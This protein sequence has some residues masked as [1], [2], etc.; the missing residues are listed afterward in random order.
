MAIIKTSWEKA[1]ADNEKDNYSSIMPTG[2]KQQ[3]YDTSI[4]PGGYL[5]HRCHVIAWKLGGIDV[6]ERNI[7]TGTQSFNIN[8]MKQFEDKV[9]NYLKEN[10]TNH[11]LYRVTP[12]FE[13]E[14]ELARGVNIEAYS[15]EDKG[16]IQFNVYVYNVQD[17]IIIDYATGKS[18][19]AEQEAKNLDLNLFDRKN[20]HSKDFIK[21]FIEELKNALKNMMNEGKNM[22]ENNS[23]NV[24]EEYNLY[25]RRKIFLDNKS[26]QG[27]DL[28]WIM[29]EKSVCIAEH[30][31]GGPCNISEIDL[32]ENAKV[33]DVYEKVEGTYVYNADI[34]D[35]LK[36]IK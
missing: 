33:G 2:F 1:N 15:I 4:V 5:Y 13:G 7:M 35:K 32:P 10:Q 22:N 24:V 11:V 25:E 36:E 8:G 29:D 19:L 14:N 20:D 9:Y 28:A 3:K 23:D 26:W 12:Y 31:D 17:G 34:T 27:K 18:E 21:E 6:E 30:G 16:K